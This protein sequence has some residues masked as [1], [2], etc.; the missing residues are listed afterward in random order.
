MLGESREFQ[1]TTVRAFPTRMIDVGWFL[2]M[3]P[4]ESSTFEKMSGI[5]NIRY[6]DGAPSHPIQSPSLTFSLSCLLPSNGKNTA[7]GRT[8]AAGAE[9]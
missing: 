1:L 8:C 4:Q 3:T 7:S 9:A 6:A 5:Y 2:V